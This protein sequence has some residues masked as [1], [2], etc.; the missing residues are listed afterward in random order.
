MSLCEA[1]GQG[2]NHR[3]PR[4]T[5]QNYTCT[6]KGFPSYVGRQV[7]NAWENMTKIRFDK[8]TANTSGNGFISVKIIS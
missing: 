2:N 1:K 6:T 4:K 7:T 3:N 5:I 8:K